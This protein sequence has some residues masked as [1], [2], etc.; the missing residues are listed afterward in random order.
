LLSSSSHRLFIICS[1]HVS[2]CDPAISLLDTD[3][4]EWKSGTWT[5]ICTRAFRGVLLTIVKRWQQFL[6][7]NRWVNKQNVVYICSGI[8][9][10]HKKKESVI[11]ATQ[12]INL[13]DIMLSER[14]QIK[15]TNVWFHLNEISRINKFTDI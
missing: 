1:P 7:I 12:W 2:S 14:C 13:E 6:S 4:K 11:H 15:G 8:L 10:C 5:D 3:P 9:S